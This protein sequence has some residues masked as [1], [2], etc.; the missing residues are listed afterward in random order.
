MR[1]DSSDRTLKGEPEITT[2]RHPEAPGTVVVQPRSPAPTTGT[3]WGA[4]SPGAASHA[5][6]SVWTPRPIPGSSSSGPPATCAS[7][8]SASVSLASRNTADQS[9]TARP[10]A[11]KDRHHLQT[12][13]PDPAFFE[14]KHRHEHSRTKKADCR[15]IRRSAPLT[16]NL[17]SDS[18]P[19]DRRRNLGLLRGDRRRH[20]PHRSQHGVS[21]RTLRVGVATPP[22]PGPFAA[23]R[24]KR[25]P[26]PR[27]TRESACRNA[28]IAPSPLAHRSGSDPSLRIRDV[29]DG[30]SAAI[31]ESPNTMSRPFHRNRG[32][33]SDTL[34]PFCVR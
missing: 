24:M 31:D 22:V 1:T 34:G 12:A 8:Y 7:T 23:R 20:L 2:D 11:T 25:R 4:D 14:T 10:G 32:H 15:S 19:V 17:V 28:S 30:P 5:P 13:R 9:P 26:R 6:R 33:Q 16:A 29:T 18:T 3:R 27:F 21:R